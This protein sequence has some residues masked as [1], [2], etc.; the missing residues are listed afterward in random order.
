MLF[1]GIQRIVSHQVEYSI[2][3]K[4]VTW[5]IQIFI[6]ITMNLDIY[7]LQVRPLERSQA[8]HDDF[9]VTTNASTTIPAGINV[10]EI[11]VNTMDDITPELNETFIVVLNSVQVVGR[12]VLAENEPQIGSLSSADVI[13]LEND[14]ARGEFFLYA[15][16]DMNVITV[17]ES[18]NLA[19]TLTVRRLGGTIGNVVVS[20]QITGST[21]TAGQDY[22]AS[23]ASITFQDGMDSSIIILSILEDD[24]PER[25]EDIIV[26][27]TGVT[28]GAS[29]AD[30]DGGR[31]VV[32]IM[33]NDRAAGVV[34]FG[35]FSR[36]AVV[37]EGEQ[38]NLTAVRTVSSLGRVRITWEV[39]GP[40]V[41]AEFVNITGS[42]VFN[43]VSTQITTLRVHSLSNSI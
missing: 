43:E 36:S 41:S 12:T 9:T 18:D 20:W 22:M 28:G 4:T 31:V 17:P 29:I 25:N 14:D 11:S 35:P 2:M 6:S 15:N 30:G 34:G 21:A 24:I 10:G 13:I 40:D 26:Q 3:K 27:L 42:A 1:P 5:Y 19:V 8:T 23:G 16:T 37:S 7:F 38:V 39:T 32:T 33:A